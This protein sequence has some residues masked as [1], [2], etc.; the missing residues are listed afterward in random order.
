MSDGNTPIEAVAN[1]QQAIIE[2]IEE[3][4]RLGEPIPEPMRVMTA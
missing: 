4:N 3:A 2:W 1:A